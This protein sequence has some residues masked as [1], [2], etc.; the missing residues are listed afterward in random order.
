VETT[1]ERA[2]ELAERLLPDRTPKRRMLVIVNPYATTVSDRLRNL[3]VYALQSRYTVEAI[4][5]QERNHAT[6]LTRE[7]A[8]EGYDV[9]VAFGG[10][11]TVNEAANGLAGSDTPLTA[12]PG[13]STNVWARVLGIPNDV[14][15]ATEHL[16]HMADEWRPRP[17]DLGRVNERHFVF[18]AGVGLDASVVKNVDEHPYRKARFGAWFYGYTA[19]GTFN[20]KYL[21]NPPHVRVRAAGRELLGVT[22]VV[23]NAELFTYFREHPIRVVEPAGLDRGTISIAVLKRA[24]VAELPTLMPKLLSGKAVSVMRSRQVEALPE[25]TVATVEAIDDRPFPVQVDGDYIGDFSE[26]EFGV[27][28]RGLM[29]VA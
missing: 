21:L 29:A 14:V 20:R 13:G 7:A 10:D 16:L 26:V 27:S 17:V 3:V 1:I 5:T 25:L 2:E 22:V 24:T 9:V 6:Q 19:L 18:S 11:G 15:D 8:S 23:Q 4:D 12:L 28:P